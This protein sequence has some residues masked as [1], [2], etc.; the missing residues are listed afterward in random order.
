M[1]SSRYNLNRLRDNIGSSSLSSNLLAHIGEM[2]SNVNNSS[3][4]VSHYH[5]HMIFLFAYEMMLPYMGTAFHNINKFVSVKTW[6]T[7]QRLHG[8]PIFFL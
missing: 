6:F 2:A 5:L 1:S 7:K 8:Y 3:W 4:F